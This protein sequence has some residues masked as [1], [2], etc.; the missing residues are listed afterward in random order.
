MILILPMVF[1]FGPLYVHEAIRTQSPAQK[2]LSILVMNPAKTTIRIGET[3]TIKLIA[4]YDNGSQETV[5][6]IK[7]KGEKKGIFP[8]N[9][10][11]QGVKTNILAKVFVIENKGIEE[12]FFRPK[13]VTIEVGET[14]LL[15]VLARYKDG[16]EGL[17][18]TEEFKGKEV[19]TFPLSASFDAKKATASITVQEYKP[20]TETVLKE[21][22]LTGSTAGICQDCHA[23]HRYR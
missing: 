7:F 2:K 20:P 8:I 23:I 1:L 14:A 21:C 13:E 6:T 3:A 10:E 17:I 9:S 11:F 5:N 15:S 22:P 4:K 16:S 12:I 18:S 19:G